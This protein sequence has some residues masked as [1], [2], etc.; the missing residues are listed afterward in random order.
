MEADTVLKNPFVHIPAKRQWALG[1]AAFIAIPTVMGIDGLPRDWVAIAYLVGCYCTLVAMVSAYVGNVLKKP[2]LVGVLKRKWLLTVI[3]GFCIATLLDHYHDQSQIVRPTTILAY[4]L[5]AFHLVMFIE[6]SARYQRKYL[7][8]MVLLVSIF[9]MS[10]TMDDRDPYG[11]HFQLRVVFW[12]LLGHLVGSWL[13][14]RWRMVRQLR[15]EH[16]QAQLRNLKSQ[17]NPH[18]LFNTLNN[19]YALAI[20]KSDQTPEMIMKLSE[21]MRYTLYQGERDRVTL[22]DEVQYLENFLSLNELRLHQRGEVIFDHEVDRSGY[23][24]APLLLIV[25]VENAFKHGLEHIRSSARIQI[26]LTAKDGRLHF[27]VENNVN[28]QREKKEPGIGLE[29]LR[30]RLA[31]IYREGYSLRCNAS[32]TAFEAVLSLPLEDKRDDVGT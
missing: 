7:V 19:L 1:I 24:I 10:P 4:S 12:L 13:L 17:I 11:P 2:I 20:E 18:F 8:S 30:Q 21:L 25:L 15:N 31:L 16:A 14:D 23:L 5:L 27:V 3:I 6:W 28:P 22:E 9:F 29:N 26:Q 32:E